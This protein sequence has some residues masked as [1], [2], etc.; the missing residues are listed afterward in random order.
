MDSILDPSSNIDVNFFDQLVNTFYKSHGKEQKEAGYIL[1]QF[2]ESSNSWLKADKILELSSNIN[3]KVD[4][5]Y[6][7]TLQFKC[8]QN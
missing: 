6:F 8:F 1:T 2:Q 5:F 3:S 7:S 4:F